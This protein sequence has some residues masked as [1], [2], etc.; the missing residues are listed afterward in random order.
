VDLQSHQ[1]DQGASDGQAPRK[2]PWRIGMPGQG[3]GSQATQAC[4]NI[5]PKTM[6]SSA[7]PATTSSIT[8]SMLA[9][10]LRL[11][12]LASAL[13]SGMRRFEPREI[14]RSVRLGL[15]IVKPSTN[16]KPVS[17]EREPFAA[18]VGYGG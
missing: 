8:V 16:L 17:A 12:V 13:M 9:K 3:Q 2:T 4:A 18:S 10:V 7:L 14:K 5:C 6:A 1:A 11:D 15:A